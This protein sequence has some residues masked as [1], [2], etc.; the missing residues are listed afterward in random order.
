MY[1]LAK[2]FVKRHFLYSECKWYLREE[3][4]IQDTLFDVIWNKTNKVK[5]GYKLSR[6]KTTKI[7]LQGQYWGVMTFSRKSPRLIRW[8]KFRLF[9]SEVFLSVLKILC[10]WTRK[11]HLLR[12]WNG[13]QGSHAVFV[14]SEKST[15]TFF[16]VG[17]NNTKEMT[18][19]FDNKKGYSFVEA[20]S[21]NWRELFE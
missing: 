14:F 13:E 6:D 10:L 3:A 12:D 2:R 5:A 18:V 20:F 4:Q 19:L 7:D 9:P 1:L 16:S 8:E 21:E 15:A 11:E 17:Y